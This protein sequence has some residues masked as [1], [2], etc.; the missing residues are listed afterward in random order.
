M[1]KQKPWGERYGILIK[2][3]WERASKREH[4]RGIETLRMIRSV[5]LKGEWGMVEE[6]YS[7]FSKR[8]HQVNQGIRDPWEGAG[9]HHIWVRLP[10]AGGAKILCTASIRTGGG[11]GAGR[12]QTA[13][14]GLIVQ[15]KRRKGVRPD[16]KSAKSWA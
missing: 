13:L 5:S 11:C 9:N 10:S 15:Q 4:R 8:K 6:R 12:A 1:P 14:E 16:F 7:G 3:R 2:S